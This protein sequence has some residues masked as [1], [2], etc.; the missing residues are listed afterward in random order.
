MKSLLLA[1]ICLYLGGE[2]QEPP[3]QTAAVPPQQ[4]APINSFEAYL[5]TTEKLKAYLL[6][7]N[8]FNDIPPIQQRISQ[9]DPLQA[10][11][12][13]GEEK[14]LDDDCLCVSHPETTSLLLYSPPAA[15]E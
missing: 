8:L 10:Y 15:K 4:S 2:Y 14:C 5:L 11:A 7:Q 9:V 1:T 12:L 6:T 3:M 13:A